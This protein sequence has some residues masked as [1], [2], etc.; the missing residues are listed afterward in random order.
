MV[1]RESEGLVGVKGEGVE[2]RA[3]LT[4]RLRAGSGR[5][6]EGG[7]PGYMLD[8]LAAGRWAAR[9]AAHLFE[10]GAAHAVF[11]RAHACPHLATHLARVGRGVWVCCW[12][13]H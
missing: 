10:Q 8:P 2:V 6:G 11:Q 3:R 5:L 9:L 4:M 12:Q 7:A 13:R 1:A